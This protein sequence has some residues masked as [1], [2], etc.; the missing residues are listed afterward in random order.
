M[1]KD[2]QDT[3]FCFI[4]FELFKDMK[5]QLSR[6]SEREPNSS[7]PQFCSHRLTKEVLCCEDS[8]KEINNIDNLDKI[9]H[10]S[11]CVMPRHV[12]I[13]IDSVQKDMSRIMDGFEA[14]REGGFYDENDWRWPK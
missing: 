4:Y 14:A 13:Q 11:M 7:Q 9:D 6:L 2:K 12:L 1:Q 10:N 8:F 3:H 5:D